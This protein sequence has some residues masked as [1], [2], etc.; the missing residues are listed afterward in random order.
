MDS[1][2]SYS[3]ISPQGIESSFDGGTLLKEICETLKQLRAVLREHRPDA[4]IHFAAK[5][6][7]EESVRLPELYYQ[8]NVVGTL[9]L[10]QAMME[11]NV[12]KIVFSSSCSVYGVPIKTPITE[13]NPIA[14]INPYGRTKAQI[15]GALQDFSRAGKISFVSLR[16]F[17]ASG[18]D[19][20]G[21]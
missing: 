15:E 18:A 17:N 6:L 1:R 11:S 7:V 14:P 20:D 4:V 21:R 10:L 9:N 13:N 16:Y 19:P 12:R 2:R 3:T 5:A 8:N